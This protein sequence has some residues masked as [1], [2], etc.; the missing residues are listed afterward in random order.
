MRALR[1]VYGGAITEARALAD[2]MRENG[3]PG[4]HGELLVLQLELEKLGVHADIANAFPGIQDQLPDRPIPAPP[5][6][7]GRTPPDPPTDLVPD[8]IAEPER[9][10]IAR[11][12]RDATCIVATAGGYWIDPITRDPRDRI[13]EAVMTDGT[14]V[15]S[16]AWATL[17]KR[18]GI[19]PPADF[20][21][22]A[23]A[24]GFQP[25]DLTPERLQQ[26]T[27]DVGL[28]SPERR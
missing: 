9:S 16:V 26:V 23:Q 8:A 19:A 4:T 7:I 15:W 5:H 3:L 14:Y 11:Y 17:V 25:P 10:Q 27:V 20:L 6:R 22:H 24:L 28:D 18:H 12:L 13:R 1:K 2:R 21:D